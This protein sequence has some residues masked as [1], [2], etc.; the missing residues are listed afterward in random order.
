MGRKNLVQ[1]KFCTVS[2]GSNLALRIYPDS[3][4]HNLETAQLQKGLVLMVN[5]KE[6]VEEGIGF[7]VPVVIFSD[8][9]YFSS[10]AQV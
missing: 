6:V 9:T 4:P 10:S 1:A 5:G 3:R 8:K 2:L 7:G